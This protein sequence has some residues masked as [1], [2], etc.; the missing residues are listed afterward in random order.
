MSRNK[1]FGI[2]HICGK[3]GE[4]SYEHVPPK[5]AFNDLTFIRAKAESVVTLGPYDVP[6]GRI[7]QGG[8][9]EYTL[10]YS[11]NNNTGGW[12]GRRF[13]NWCY[14]GMNILI[15]SNGNP[16]LI[17]MNYLF[18]LAI[19]KQI[20]S[21][22]CSINA[23]TFS[24]AN[25]ELISFLLNKE[26]KYLNPK[27]RF[28][29]YYNIEGRARYVGLAAKINIF[30]NTNIP[31][32]EISFPPLGYVMT[33]ESEPPDNRLFEITHFAR[34]DFNEFAVM[35]LKLPVLPTYLWYPG[36][37]RTKAEIDKALNRDRND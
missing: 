26:K 1:V 17:Y 6:R 24:K 35:N 12:Y 21:M 19:L 9:G 30:D 4:L 2:C 14:Q 18:P 13:V 31:L 11:C 7:Q 32:S 22:F 29:C 3:N 5:A 27:Y 20:I 37:Y 8:I 23:N 15:R 33:L 16:S 36:D 10:C 28:F 34:Y 25:P